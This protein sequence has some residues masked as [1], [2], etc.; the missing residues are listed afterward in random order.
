MTEGLIVGTLS[1]GEKIRVRGFAIAY[2]YE[3]EGEGYIDIP[4][5]TG[6]HVIQAERLPVSLQA[7]L[8]DVIVADVKRREGDQ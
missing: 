6:P 8:V 3:V 7:A 1:T 2:R 5:T 4:M